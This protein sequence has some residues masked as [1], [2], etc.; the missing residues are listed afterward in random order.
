MY[1]YTSTWPDLQSLSANWQ[2]EEL[3]SLRCEDTDLFFAG[4]SPCIYLM[5]WQ[6]VSEE[7]EDRNLL[8]TKPSWVA[9]SWLDFA[10]SQ[11]H[12]MLFG[13]WHII[14]HSI[15]PLELLFLVPVSPLNFFQYY[16]L[17]SACSFSLAAWQRS[18]DLSFLFR[19]N[20]MYEWTFWPYAFICLKR[21]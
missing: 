9:W 4:F 8:F 20:L 1:S 2:R 13:Q 3:T 17:L 12:L 7:I 15:V 11:H 10:F 16:C 14:V 6:P 18:F 21:R 19:H 5:Y